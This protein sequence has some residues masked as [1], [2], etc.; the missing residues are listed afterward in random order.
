MNSEYIMEVEST[1]F[2]SKR[3]FLCSS[4]GIF[5][6]VSDK[7]VMRISQNLG[8]SHF[9]ISEED[10]SFTLIPKGQIPSHRHGQSQI[11]SSFKDS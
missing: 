2:F 6:M 11:P 3:Y 8:S 5:T 10:I 9:K 1:L 4:D 7:A